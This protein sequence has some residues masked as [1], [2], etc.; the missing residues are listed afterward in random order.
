MKRRVRVRPP[1]Q[2]VFGELA[3]TPQQRAVLDHA[4]GGL[5]VLGGPG[6]GKTS[7]AVAATAERIAT[8]RPVLLLA[9]D[10]QSAS[11]LRDRVT[12]LSGRTT[13]QPQ[14]RTI[15]S[16][17]RALV[18]RFVS[19]PG[20]EPRLLTA[21]EQEFRIREL[22]AGA[23]PGVWPETLRRA[24]S[25]GG[26][27]R[28]VRGALARARQLGMDPEQLV[29]LGEQAGEPSWAALGRF[30]DEY[31]DVLDAEQVIDYA[32]LIH[33][34]RVLVSDPEIADEVGRWFGGIWLDEVAE[35]DPAQLALVRAVA[36]DDLP[37]IGLADPDS[38][39][40]RF[41]GAHPRAAAE[42][43][44]LFG[45]EVVT[46]TESFR[47]PAA[48]ADA[49]AGVA[50]RLPL[51][52]PGEAA[53]RY[54]SV[55]GRPGG[56]VGVRLFGSG[57][58]HAAGVARLLRQA[59]LEGGMPWS[60]MAVLV[61]SGRDQIPPIVRSLTQHGVP[62][63]VA[64]DE[65]GLGADPAVQPL[66]TALRVATAGQSTPDQARELLL[67]G[68][69]GFDS[70][71]L[72]VLNRRLRV[73]GPDAGDG[74]LL[75]AVLTDPG[76]VPAAETEREQRLLQRLAERAELLVSAGAHL[77]RG[78]SVEEVLWRLWSGTDWPARLRDTALGPAGGSPAA[79]RDLDAVVAL[80][81]LAADFGTRAGE[82]SVA[83]FLSEV[84]AQELPADTEREST[85]RGRGVRV[86]TAHRSKGLQW[87]L[88]VVAG[89]QE[90]SWPDIRRR[91]SLFDPEKLLSHGLGAG[92]STGELVA[93]ERRLFHLA[94][95]RAETH[96]V[97]TAVAGTDSD[98]EQPSRFLSE[99]GVDPASEPA[100]PGRPVTLRELVAELRRAA[101]DQTLEPGLREGAAVRLARLA[102]QRD[103]QGNQLVPDADPARWWG[104]GE[105]TSQTYTGSSHRIRLTPSRLETILAC[106]R[107]Y[108]LSTQVNAEDSTTPMVL[109]SV[110][111]SLVEHMELGDIDL[112]RA[113]EHL[114]RIWPDIPF[115]ARWRA[116]VELSDA[117]EAL[118]RFDRWRVA[119]A[120]ADV[121]GIEA[122]FSFDI[123]VSGMNVQV[124]GKADRVERAEDG[125][126]RVIDFKT[127]KTVP[128]LAAVKEHDQL[129]VYQLAIECGA[130]ESIAPG[131]SG[132]GGAA[133]VFLR[134]DARGLPKTMNQPALSLDP[135]P[136]G[137]P[138]EGAHPTW[139]HHRIELAARVLQDGRFD[140]TTG[141]HCR[142]CQF[143]KSCP[144]WPEGKQVVP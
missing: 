12:A 126:L 79:H 92:T 135:R 137:D 122:P 59:H 101:E 63:E 21:P 39:I 35:M 85:L 141:D 25:T 111:H 18:E 107:K 98:A 36:T 127:G 11:R 99:L 75:A 132:S 97:V 23:G 57:D 124:S 112:G 103:A 16:F 117:I 115:E 105:V 83:A 125:S 118:R 55:T 80:F 62:V 66:L 10:R 28:Q 8:D 77:G 90:G 19:D 61:R 50:R 14:V 94:C 20:G 78:G 88:V 130:F 27:A 129:G 1:E 49:L 109:G 54:R 46:L 138:E 53:A 140:A 30:F 34:A 6:T 139:V 45:A 121:V 71:E 2:A 43:V 9:G 32:E 86:L 70:V 38:A 68:W 65:I 22:L 3:W 93:T 48:V 67:S 24:Y 56:S 142:Y 33:R 51:P 81:S 110:I 29:A 74:T 113:L 102:E 116:D 37:V 87:P 72:R 42:F 69:G 89:V 120:H 4:R 17:S 95:G 47:M 58:A 96:L 76:M 91:G 84:A 106:P 119:N 133:L 44:R 40:F 136:G 114:E 41:R 13:I 108:F 64:G 131:A 134:A 5:L 26:F 143:R 144:A 128:S 104:M 7:L 31:L 100:H 82:R 15:H 123:E 52:V 73:V 60:D